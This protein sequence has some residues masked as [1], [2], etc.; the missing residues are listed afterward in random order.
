M[1]VQSK[2]GMG[3]GSLIFPIHVFSEVKSKETYSRHIFKLRSVNVSLGVLLLWYSES[4]YYLLMTCIF[5]L[6]E[7]KFST[8]SGILSK[9]KWE[10]PFYPSYFCLQTYQHLFLCCFSPKYKFY[11]SNKEIWKIQLS[12]KIVWGWR[13]NSLVLSCSRKSDC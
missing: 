11:Q 3:Y 4:I 12:T 2:T 1:V 7:I 6:M 10:P 9:T 13:A 8:I 5:I